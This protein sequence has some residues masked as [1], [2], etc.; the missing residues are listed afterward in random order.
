MGA[1]EIREH[2]DDGALDDL[3]AVGSAHRP[4]KAREPAG[5]E[6]E[7]AAGARAS[8]GIQLA[9]EHADFADEA[10]HVGGIGRAGGGARSRGGA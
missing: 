6:R 1:Q 2:R 10:A 7:C 9:D 8:G 3:E 4:S 5:R